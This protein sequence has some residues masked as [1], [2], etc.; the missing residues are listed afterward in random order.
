MTNAMNLKS[1]VLNSDG[2]PLQTWPLSL[3]PARDAVSAVVSDTAIALENWDAVFRSPSVE[4]AVPKVLMLGSYFSI[5]ASPKFCR[6]SILL[7]DKYK[8]QY[9]GNSFP[10]AELTFD[11]V[12]PRANGGQ[13]CWE[14]ILTCCVACNAGKRNRHAN[15]SGRKGATGVF[16][17]LKAPRQPAMAELLR[18]GLE[19]LDAD[20]R[21]NWHDYLYWN[22]ELK[23]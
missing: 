12:I 19:F 11:H 16:R 9:C 13:T 10:A 22:A 3:I 18:A 14:N 2:Q 21:E 5:D 4:I 6:R 7:R 17:P 23:A 15:F 1:L 8:C 20:V